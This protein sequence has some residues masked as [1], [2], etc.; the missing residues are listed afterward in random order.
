M[1]WHPYSI[2][3][4]NNKPFYVESA[5]KEFLYDGNHTEYIDAV[6]SW[7]ISIHGHNH[8]KIIENV[9]ET[10]SR[11]DHII[12]AGQTHKTAIEL[13]EK[14]ISITS[15]T[16]HSVF[17]SD[18]GSCAVDIAIKMAYQYF[19]NL[20][21]NDK[22]E[23][24]HFSSSYHGDTIGAMSVSGKSSFNSK[25]ADLGFYSPEFLSPNCYDC[26][27]KKNPDSCKIECIQSI[28]QY[29]YTN[30][31][32]ICAIIIEPVVQAALG[33]KFYKKEV[34]Q[35]LEKICRTNNILLILDEVF[36]GFGRLGKL[37]AY[38][39]AEVKP[40]IITLAKGLSGGVLPLAATLVNLK[41]FEGFNSADADQAFYHGHTMTGNPSAC[42][43]AL[44]SIDLFESENRIEDIQILENYFKDKLTYF[45]TYFSEKIFNPR[46]IG[47]IF[48]FEI[49]NEKNH[50]LNTSA[51]KLQEFSFENKILLRPLGNTI[52]ITPP[53]IIGKTSLD[54]IF[55]TLENY[56][57]YQI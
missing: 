32:K 15:P 37:F 33:M 23:I 55:S 40:D 38:Q 57:Q 46:T 22:K 13:A 56:L 42:S 28:E 4:N 20:G 29:A 7:W 16:F 43:A 39:Y 48:A 24:L 34:L 21:L 49:G 45:Q 17:Y 41:I 44:A 2:L 9:K 27:L 11:L 26:P 36:T 35:K 3:K 30:S 52:Y 47:A 10:L 25:F 19:Q 8:P 5:N 31:E 14:L 50:Y 51:K 6:S 18:N 1:I 12:L 54:K 53:Y